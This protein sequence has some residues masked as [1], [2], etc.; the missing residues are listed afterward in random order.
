M[1]IKVKHFTIDEVDDTSDL[2]LFSTSVF[3]P[4]NGFTYGSIKYKSGDINEEI[5]VEERC[6]M[7]YCFLWDKLEEGKVLLWAKWDGKDGGR[8]AVVTDGDM[9]ILNENGKTID[10]VR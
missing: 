9:F 8:E 6:H 2:L 10:R 7:H 5:G 3:E 1:Y 4:S